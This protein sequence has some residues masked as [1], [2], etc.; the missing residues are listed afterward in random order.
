MCGL[1]SGKGGGKEGLWGRGSRG[2]I[3]E[4]MVWELVEG[5]DRGIEGQG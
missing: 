4:G 5:R 2:G 3:N 1:G